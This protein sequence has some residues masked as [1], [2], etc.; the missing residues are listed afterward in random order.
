MNNPKPKGKDYKQQQEEQNKLLNNEMKTHTILTPIIPSFG[1]CTR[2][3]LK[4][5]SNIGKWGLLD[6]GGALGECFNRKKGRGEINSSGLTGYACPGEVLAIMGPSGCGKSTL[7]DALAG[8]LSSRTRQKGEILINGQKQKL[9]YGT[10]A[11]VTHEDTLTWTLTVREAVYY[12]AQLQLPITMSK[13]EKREV[14]ERT[15]REMGLQDSMDTRIGEWGRK[16]LSS[17]Q[18][19]RVSIC[20]ELLK[21]PKLLFLDEP[22][23]GLDSAA[24]YFVMNRIVK[25]ARE[26]GMTVI[27]SIHQPTSEVFQLLHNLCLLSSGRMIY[28]GPSLLANK[29]FAVNGFACP[30]QQNPADHYLKMINTDFDEDIEQGT[31]SKFTV[32]E[33][34]NLLIASYGSSDTCK[35]M[36]TLVAEIRKHEGG[37]TEKKAS[38]ANLLTQCLILTKRSFVNMYRDLGYYWLRLAIYVALGFGLGSVFYNVGS[39]YNSI[40]ERGSL[41]MF[42]ASLLTIMAIGGFPSFVEDLKTQRS[43]RGCSIRC[44]PH[45]ILDT[46]SATHLSNPRCNHLLPRRPS[47]RKR[48]IYV[49]HFSALCMHDA[50]REPNDD[51]CNN[52]AKLPSGLIVGAGIQGLMMLSGGFFQLPKD[53]PTTFWKYPMYYIAFHKYAYQGLYKNEFE[54]RRF[55]N[56]QLGGPSTIEGE[57]ILRDIWQVEMGYSKWTDLAVLFGMVAVYRELDDMKKR[58]KEMEDE[59]AA[60]REMQAKVEQEMGAVQAD[61]A[62][63]AN[64]ANR[65]EVDARSVFVGNV[66]YACTPEEVQQHFQSCGTVN[67]VTIRTNKYGQP[68]GYA[69][70][71]FLETEAVEQALL[72]NESELHGR[73][74]KVSAK[75]T[76]IPGM[77]Q[78]CPRRSTPFMGYRPRAPYMPTPYLYSPYG[79][80]KVPRFRAS[81]RYSPYF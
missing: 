6:V 10:S 22:T 30:P 16:G 39:S 2:D 54:G 80:G 52:H 32:E 55:R 15:I 67:R 56:D 63:A 1:V 13:F 25:L 72:L 23:S 12:S 75:R 68:K 27:S 9:A 43:L 35:T 59:A 79:Y 34:I 19:R 17:G 70:V 11:Y 60:L 42:I 14:A 18:K 28:F 24:S 64:R 81:M 77:K 38:Q 36:K 37:P 45:S 49:L 62:A 3:N 65:E 48:R 20:I 50:G 61:P 69:Y 31:G 57:T 47:S 44:R 53:L 76:N 66:D 26:Y 71:E 4:F 8:R 74:L 33:V 41:L 46:V 40:H 5:S 29:F 78:F 58:L 7:L 51:R 73:Q 21:R